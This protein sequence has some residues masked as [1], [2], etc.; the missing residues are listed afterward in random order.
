VA[1]PA[2]FAAWGPLERAQYLEA[3]IFLQQYL[4]SSQG[5][6]VAMAHSVEGRMPFLD[7]RVVEFANRLPPRMKLRGL[8]EKWLLKQLGQELLPAEIAGRLKRPYRAP[9][10]RSFFGEAAQAWVKDVLS[11]E[12]LKESG[13][14]HAAAVQQLAHKIERGQAVGETDDMALAG[15]LSAQLVYRQFVAAFRKA[16]PAGAGDDVKVCDVRQACPV[17]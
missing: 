9:I 16:A 7:Y 10:H 17:L 14:F 15:I 8:T 1:Y 4:L 5:D 3:S 12:A 13:L 2:G 6:R 11:P